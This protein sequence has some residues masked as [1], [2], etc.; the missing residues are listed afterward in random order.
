MNRTSCWM[1]IVMLALS[2]I[3]L[4]VAAEVVLYDNSQGDFVWVPQTPG[5]PF[6][7]FDPTQPPT[8]SGEQTPFGLTHTFLFPETS[9]MV[10]VNSIGVDPESPPRIA[11]AVDDPFTVS[12]GEGGEATVTPATTFRPGEIV[13]P[14]A[15]WAHRADHYWYTLPRR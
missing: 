1:T 14:D 5:G 3:A 10:A 15:D 12:G 6:N 8:Q 4:P 13:G 2:G 7:Y 11:I 9:T